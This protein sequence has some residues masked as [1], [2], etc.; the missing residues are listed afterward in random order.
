MIQVHAV[1]LNRGQEGVL[2]F[3]FD[4]PSGAGGVIV[5]GRHLGQQSVTQAERR[6]TKSTELAA[7]EQ[8]C[9]YGGAGYDDF[10][11]AQADSVYVATLGEGEACQHFG[12]A[13]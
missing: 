12:N 2:A 1:M 10:C 11:P 3:R 4:L 13:A 8:L 6:I 5:I 7:F 9:E